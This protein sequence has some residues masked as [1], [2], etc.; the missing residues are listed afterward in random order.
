[1]EYAVDLRL[2]TKAEA[3]GLISVLAWIGQLFGY[4]LPTAQLKDKNR[5][6]LFWFQEQLAECHADYT[7][8]LETEH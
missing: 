2:P 1:M 5:E 6:G 8:H 3:L 7:E 4:T